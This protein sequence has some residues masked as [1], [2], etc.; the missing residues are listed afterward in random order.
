MTPIEVTL[1][2]DGLSGF[3]CGEYFHIDGV[4]ETYNRDGVFQITNIKHSIN[5][6]GWLTTIEAGWRIIN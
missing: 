3:S 2:I 1:T 5:N 4:P 6:D